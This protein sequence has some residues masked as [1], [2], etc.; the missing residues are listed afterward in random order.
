M[1]RPMGDASS[2][3]SFLCSE[4]VGNITGPVIGLN[5]GMYI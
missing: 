1:S 3:C 2:A 4:D 5:G